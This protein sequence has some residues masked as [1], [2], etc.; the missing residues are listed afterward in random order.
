[1]FC[2]RSVLFVL[3]L[4]G[5]CATSFAQIEVEVLPD[6]VYGHKDGMALTFDAI[7]P[8]E[9][10]KGIGI[11]YIFSSGYTSEWIEPN[12]LIRRSLAQG[13]RFAT[14]L[15]HGFTLF[16]VRHGSN[17]RYTVPEILADVRRA[18]R[19]IR[20]HA[21][22]YGIDPEKI[23]VFGNSAGGHLAL[24]LGTAADGGDADA[25][26]PVERASS[27]V[28]AV[29][30]YYPPVDMRDRSGP[31]ASLPAMR[32]DPALQA[33]LSP[34]LHATADDAPTLFVHGDEDALV[35][36]S[37]SERMHAALKDAGVAA[38][39]IVLKGAG[40][41]FPGNYGQEAARALTGWFERFLG[42]GTE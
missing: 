26:D 37:E 2:A 21:A 25:E 36:L 27:R 30:A 40:H 8:K 31:E 22:D 13:G 32:F 20:L 4:A 16:F 5:Y 6:V 18:T 42:D 7:T 24:M 38:E 33:E 39:L 23:G 29:V 28:A 9:N 12:E 41:A 34:I 1:M 35:P 17:P 10:A 11:I 3:V 15:E 14:V 19:Y